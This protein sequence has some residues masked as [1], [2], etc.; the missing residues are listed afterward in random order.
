MAKKEKSWA[1][2]L[3]EAKRNATVNMI[4]SSGT[5]Y[6]VRPLTLDELAAEEGLPDDL[7]RVAI[8]DKVPG[9]IVAE[10]VELLRKGNAESLANA[11]KLSQDTVALRDRIV[12]RSVQAP[13]LKPG[14][15]PELDPYDLHEIAMVAQHRLAVDEDGGLVDPFA[16]FPEARQ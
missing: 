11:R 4:A 5:K 6:S 16:T 7:L 10:Q 9:G 1:S 12:L 14:D 2:S 13:K 15:L 8:I 3:A